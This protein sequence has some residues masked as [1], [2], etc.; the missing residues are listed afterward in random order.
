MSPIILIIILLFAATVGLLL[1]KNDNKPKKYKTGNKFMNDT[2]SGLL[3][4]FKTNYQYLNGAYALKKLFSEYEGVHLRIRR[5]TDD[6][7]VDLT[8]DKYGN[9][10]IPLNYDTWIGAS[11]AYVV[12]WYDQSGNERHAI[13]NAREPEMEYIKANKILDFKSQ[14]FFDLPDGTVPF[15]NDPYTFVVHHGIVNSGASGLIGS[16]N[17]GTNHETNCL[18]RSTNEYRNYWW[19][20][21]VLSSS[22]VF[23][24]DQVV[25][26][27][28]D[29]V[30]TRRSVY[31]PKKSDITWNV[32]NHARNSGESN[33]TIGKTCCQEYANGT[34]YSVMI[35]NRAL[36]PDDL[37]TMSKLLEAN[38]YVDDDSHT[39]QF[40]EC[41]LP[42][43]EFP[44][45]DTYTTTTSTL[46][47]DADVIAFMESKSDIVACTINQ[48][49]NIYF[50]T[51]PSSKTYT[52]TIH[53][54]VRIQGHDT[55]IKLN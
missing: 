19:N 7:E 9:V 27:V 46:S 49:G 3:D 39:V 35:F 30:N 48:T 40:T 23:E 52:E 43:A 51:N 42:E 20:N 41:K 5:S 33:N 26:S 4:D 16:G 53:K 38:Y 14:G 37:F 1:M 34:L 2:Q 17:Y 50:Y 22:N 21:D 15:G 28:Y 12:K 6:Q 55:F 32:V 10:I 25:V 31:V 24:P 36:E 45:D 44:I 54:L 13:P 11:S 18:R 47:S 29:T 8:F